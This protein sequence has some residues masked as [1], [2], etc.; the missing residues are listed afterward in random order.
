VSDAAR[1]GE[2]SGF[3]PDPRTPPSG[4][5]Q[6]A[7]GEPGRSAVLDEDGQRP[8]PPPPDGAREMADVGLI[9]LTLAAFGI[10]LGL[11]RGLE[12]L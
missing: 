7:G 8:A 3:R 4:G 9:V 1:C 11:V 10:L 6:A 5:R 2:A 12:R